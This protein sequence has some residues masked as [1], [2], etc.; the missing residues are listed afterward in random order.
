MFYM[1]RGPLGHPTPTPRFKPAQGLPTYSLLSRLSAEGP[2]SDVAQAAAA[3]VELAIPHF[4]SAAI[5][6]VAEAKSAASFHVNVKLLMVRT[7]PHIHLIYHVMASGSIIVVFQRPSCC[8]LQ[9]LG[10]TVNRMPAGVRHV[11]RVSGGSPR[12]H[13]QRAK[14][15]AHGA[16]QVPQLPGS[17]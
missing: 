17:F 4:T 10:S 16:P 13:V 15:A 7:T 9:W 11:L 3:A 5:F 14:P 12:R 6:S 1:R 2:A 8:A